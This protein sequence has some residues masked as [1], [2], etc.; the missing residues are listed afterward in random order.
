MITLPAV[1]QF[2]TKIIFDDMDNFVRT[3]KTGSCEN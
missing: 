3:A 1:A 2:F